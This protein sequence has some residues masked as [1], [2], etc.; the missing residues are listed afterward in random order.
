M[1]VLSG[2]DKQAYRNLANGFVPSKIRLALTPDQQEQVDHMAVK[3]GC[4][5]PEVIE[6]ARR[7]SEKNRPQ[8]SKQKTSQKAKGVKK[9][10]IAGR[11]AVSKVRSGRNTG[12]TPHKAPE[13][14]GE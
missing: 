5:S 1:T 13:S 7:L 12:K 6:F 8:E 2:A 9:G 3:A 14:N 11:R 4:Y 10:R